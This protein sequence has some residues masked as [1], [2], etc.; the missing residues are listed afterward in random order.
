LKDKNAIAAAMG[1]A[2]APLQSRSELAKVLP[3]E[4]CIN[5][6]IPAAMRP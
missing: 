4:K 3:L 1:P 6:R 2:A 5:E